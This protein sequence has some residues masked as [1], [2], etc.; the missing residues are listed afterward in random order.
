[1][2]TGH[3]SS[4][5]AFG[6]GEL[7]KRDNAKSKK[8]RVV[9]L[10]I[11]SC[12]TFLPS[13]IKIFPGWAKK[14]HSGFFSFRAVKFLFRT[15]GPFRDFPLFCLIDFWTIVAPKLITHTTAGNQSLICII[16]KLYRKNSLLVSG[17]SKSFLSVPWV[18]KNMSDDSEK[19]KLSAP[20]PSNRD[21]NTLKY[22]VRAQ[23]SLTQAATLSSPDSEDDQTQDPVE[24]DE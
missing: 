3:K 16:K 20:K 7:T 10:V 17:L 24:P 4:P 2:K 6:S 9:I 12:S 5:W 23:P 14:S 11:W 8:G 21:G 1:M 22:L 13:I 19:R 18:S 15:C